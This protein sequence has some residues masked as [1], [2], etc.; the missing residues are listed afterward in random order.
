MLATTAEAEIC[1]N[2]M[3]DTLDYAKAKKQKEST[4]KFSFGSEINVLI[5]TDRKLGCAKGLQDYLQNSTDITA[6]LVTGSDEAQTIIDQ[7]PIDFLIIVGYLKDRFNYDTMEAVKKINRFASIIMY[8]STDSCIINEC[9]RFKI[10][11]NFHREKP[12]AEFVDYMRKCYAKEVAKQPQ[13]TT[14]EQ[15]RLIAI[16]DEINAAQLREQEKLKQGKRQRFKDLFVKIA[17]TV[18][19]TFMFVAAVFFH[20]YKGTFFW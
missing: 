6:D 13:N 7:K 14:R 9:F 8:G 12:I 1:I 5:I 16:Q 18:G 15:L 10:T 3:L 2:D 19:V 17:A 11:E 20:I 4:Q